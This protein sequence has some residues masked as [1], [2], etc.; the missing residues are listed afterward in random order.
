MISRAAKVIK[1]HEIL[2]DQN[3]QTSIHRFIEDIGGID[4]LVNIEYTDSNAIITYEED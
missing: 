2:I 4:N 1:T 3:V